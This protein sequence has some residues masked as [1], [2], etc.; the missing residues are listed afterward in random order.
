MG[1]MQIFN[2]YPL[3]YLNDG[4]LLAYKKSILYIVDPDSNYIIKKYV[5]H[6][7]WK[8]KYLSRIK[9]LHRTLRL[10]IRNSIQIDDSTVLF[11]VNKR[12][13]EVNLLTGIIKKGF[14]P[15]EGMRALNISEVKGVKGFEDSFLFGAYI[16]PFKKKE[17]PIYRRVSTTE[18]QK[19]FT[20]SADDVNHVHNIIPDRNNKCLWILTGDFGDA[21]A[22]WIASDNFRIVHRVIS[23]NQE[24]RACEAFILDGK[25]IYATDSPF[26]SN[27][28]RVLEKIDE[29]WQSRKLLDISGS[30]IY[31]CQWN[32]KLVFST[33]VEPNGQEV[34]RLALFSRKRGKGIFDQYCHIYIGDLENSFKDVYS[35][36]K[37]NWPYPLCQFGTLQFPSGVNNTKKLLVYH[38]AT[39]QHDCK[40]I[41]L[42]F[43]P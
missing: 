20:F 21:A 22:I 4:F 19:V 16:N 42:E 7:G 39:K 31:G 33:A 12:F 6:L 34:G 37:D 10:G 2:F 15:P 11:F 25:L 26:S 18:W 32:K 29:K 14:V 3:L 23:G 36:E 43:N 13:Y 35:V 24:A 17:V 30:C 40:T 27:S 28:I 1:I 38:M 5:L 8:E 9:I 41:T